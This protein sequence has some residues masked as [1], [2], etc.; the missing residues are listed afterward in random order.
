[1]VLLL[2]CITAEAQKQKRQVTRGHLPYG[3]VL[4]VSLQIGA[5]AVMLN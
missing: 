4:R 3:A 2:E 5:D 1:M